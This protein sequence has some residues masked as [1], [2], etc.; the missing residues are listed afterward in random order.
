MSTNRWGSAR[1][2]S[3]CGL[4]VA[5][6]L[7]TAV[8][9]AQETPHTD[10]GVRLAEHHGEGAFIRLENVKLRERVAY[11]DGAAL[12]ALKTPAGAYRAYLSTLTAIEEE[13]GIKTLLVNSALQQGRKRPNCDWDMVVVK[14]Y[15]GWRAWEEVNGSSLRQA[16]YAHRE[17]AVANDH[18][19]VAVPKLINATRLSR[20]DDPADTMV[21]V[22]NHLEIAAEANYAD[23]SYPGSTGMEAYERYQGGG[24]LADTPRELIVIADVPADLNPPVAQWTRINI[25]RYPSLLQLAQLTRPSEDPDSWSKMSR[26]K[27]A[28][29]ARHCGPLTVPTMPESSVAAASQV[30]DQILALWIDWFM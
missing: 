17:A 23:G 18:V 3:H 14:Y 11:R 9:V 16:A 5:V 4:I 28:A 29:I 12:G 10:L 13:A 24:P 25:V 15:P 20:P 1:T 22:V 19:V 7:T 26:H 6:V 2:W 21:Y 27:E 8:A 30:S